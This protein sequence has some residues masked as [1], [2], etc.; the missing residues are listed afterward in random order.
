MLNQIEKIY[1]LLV[2]PDI[3][4]WHY[5]CAKEKPFQYAF[6][7]EVYNFD[8]LSEMIEE[9]YKRIDP[10][11]EPLIEPKEPMKEN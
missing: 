5:P 9:A 7:G 3:R 4:I 2:R 8:T 1:V 6:K 11:L 10:L